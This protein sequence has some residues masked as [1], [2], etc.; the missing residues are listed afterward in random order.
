MN[1]F[2]K[3]ENPAPPQWRPSKGPVAIDSIMRGNTPE[4]S[5]EL[6]QKV[7]STATVQVQTILRSTLEGRQHCLPAPISQSCLK[8]ELKKNI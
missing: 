2:P 3:A 7:L 4:L 8:D 1:G 5:P 6:F